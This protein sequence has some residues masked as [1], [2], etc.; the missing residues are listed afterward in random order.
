MRRSSSS[1]STNS[2]L[3][4]GAGAAVLRAAAER[5]RR[6][7]RRVVAVNATPVRDVLELA[8]VERELKL[9]ATPSSPR[10][11]IGAAPISP[12]LPA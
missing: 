5:A 2:P 7:G 12:S 11:A 6:S 3:V 9:V 1:T 4:D 10:P 8:G